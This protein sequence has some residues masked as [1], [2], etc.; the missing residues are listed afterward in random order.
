MKIVYSL[1]DIIIWYHN[2]YN[3]ITILYKADISLWRTREQG[4]E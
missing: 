2:I 4:N 3:V 1:Y